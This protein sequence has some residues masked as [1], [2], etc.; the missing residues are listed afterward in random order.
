MKILITTGIFPPDIGGPAS[1]IPRTATALVKLGHDVRVLT[2]SEPVH[3]KR[4]D[5]PY[6]FVIHRVNRRLPF[7]WRSFNYIR[8]ILRL[9]RNTDIIYANGLF[10]E[11]GIVSLSL[12]KPLVMKV[13]GDKAWERATNRGWVA[14]DFSIFQTK[15]YGIKVEILK[16]L[17][18][19]SV[20]HADKVIVPR[21]YLAN[22]ITGW[23]IEKDR[24]SIVY[25]GS[26]PTNNVK[27]VEIPLPTQKK[28]VT[29]GRLIG[30]K[31]IDQLIHAIAMLEGTG[32]IIVGDGP[33]RSHLESVAKT[34]NISDRVYFA[35]ARTREETLAL[36]AACDLMVLNSVHEAFPHVLLEAVSL[37]LP[38]V[39]TA[40][41]GIPE[42]IEHGKTGFLVEP[43]NT[44]QL[45]RT[46]WE[47]LRKEIQLENTREVINNT[48]RRFSV[49]KMITETEKVLKGVYRG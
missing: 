37:H 38:V 24:V 20:R 19:W 18:S 16:W 31:C 25:N 41:G 13:V 4:D 47:I 49:S 14:D 17:R 11:T 15:N 27:P 2:S 26:E 22:T 32:L 30:L 5:E 33:L 45:S 42:M 3:L 40:V 48:L 29:V 21:Q 36:M 28:V 23:G 12:R 10:T 7:L 9:A 46:I 6:P 1:Y 35:G 8:Y 39:A 44:D 34:H 43:N